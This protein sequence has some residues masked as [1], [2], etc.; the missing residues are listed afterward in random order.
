M[1]IL[2]DTL[3]ESVEIGGKNVPIETDFKTCLCVILACEDPTLTPREKQEITLTNL[4]PSRPPQTQEAMLQAKWFM[5]CGKDGDAKEGKRQPRVYSFS[6]DAEMIYAGFRQIHGIDL[7]TAEL[8]WWQFVA[9]FMALIANQNTAFGSLVTLRLKVK[10]GKAT[11]EE[12][13]AAL[14]MGSLFTLP[15]L[16]TRSLEQ[17][18]RKRLFDEKIAEAERKRKPNGSGL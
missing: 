7:A 15:E 11:K 12:K 2:V 13:K 6:Q 17:R 9:L 8:H 4:Y 16:D 1:N 10:T 14:E 5:D 18:E 3:P